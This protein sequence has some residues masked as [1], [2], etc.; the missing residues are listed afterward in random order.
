MK[1][2]QSI[3]KLIRA[4]HYAVLTADTEDE[5]GVALNA[6]GRE[7]KTMTRVK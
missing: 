1:K 4:K 5:I 6:V 3:I 7:F 2:L